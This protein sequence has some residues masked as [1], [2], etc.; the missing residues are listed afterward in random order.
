V[1]TLEASLQNDYEIV[2]QWQGASGPALRG[3][4]KAIAKAT[5]K[6]AIRRKS[7]K[8][9]APFV[10]NK[11]SVTIEPLLTPDNYTD[12]ILD[13]LELPKTGANTV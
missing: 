3:P 7:K 13:G 2:T 12:K 8:F 6:L 10:I 11:E 1:K 9:F 4:N 5:A